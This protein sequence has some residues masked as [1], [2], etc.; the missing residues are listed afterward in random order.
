M[1]LL[2]AAAVAGVLVL[3]ALLGWHL[4]HQDTATAKAVAHG[5]IVPAPAFRLSRVEGSGRLTLASLRGKAV[6]LN[7]WQSECGPC[8]REMPQL[9]RASVRWAAKGVEVV[10]IDV[11][12]FKGP[13]RDFVRK[14]GVTYPIGFDG[15]GDTVISYGIVGT[16]TSFFVDTHGRIVKRVT[17]PMTDA[18]LDAHIRRALAS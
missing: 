18:V 7:F 15:V 11:L 2:R 1:R 6:V 4:T 16:P 9:Q 13:A 8:K 10:G 5:K 17:G 12:D 3:A 14:H